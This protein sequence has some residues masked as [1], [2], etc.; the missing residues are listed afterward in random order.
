MRRAVIATDLSDMPAAYRAARRRISV[1]QRAGATRHLLPAYYHLSDLYANQM[2]P[3]PALQALLQVQAL[4]DCRLQ[5]N[6]RLNT[7]IAADLG[8]QYATLGDSARARR[9]ERRA[10]AFLVRDTARS[11]FYVCGTLGL[12][13]WR[14]RDWP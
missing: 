14:L 2:Q 7:S 5:P 6:H 11:R 3:L 10:R 1:A 12:L 13:N 4:A 9:D 8:L